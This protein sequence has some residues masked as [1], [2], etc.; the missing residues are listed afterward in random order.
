M[1]KDYLPV[2]KSF[3]AEQALSSEIEAA[4][5][6]P[7]VRCQ[8]ITATM[9]DVYLVTSHQEH[10][11]F[12]L[13][14][15]NQHT[16]AEI[17]A[18]WQFVNYLFAEGVSVAPAIAT[19]SSEYVLPISAPEGIRYGVLTTFVAGEHLRK[20]PGLDAVRAYGRLV[21]QIHALADVMPLEL[22]R[23][24]NDVAVI[25]NQ[26]IAAFEA[27]VS[28]H[29]EEIDYLHQCVPIL[30]A[31][32]ETLPQEKPF[33]GMIHGDVIRANSQVGDDGAVA[34]LDFDLCGLG[35]RV[36]D[37]AS[38]L[39]V[40]R[41]LPDELESER[42]FLEGYKEVRPLTEIEQEVIP[43]FEAI[44]AIFSIG[45]PAMNVYHWGSAY[46]HAYLDD[47]L[48]RLRYAMTKII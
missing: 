1:A 39:I 40:I 33:Y 43:V 36:Y 23:P 28:D 7:A 24:A 44:R 37:I 32:I 42:A 30:L 34:I 3:I 9:R 26:S 25:L 8:L 20:R 27:E 48:G 5:G 35:W 31:K 21:A 22:A 4:Y 12:Y 13:Y 14:R 47:S 19:K 41:G 38:Y 46:L 17:S 6:L 10:Y 29:Q 18:E 11:I 45:I 16:Q 15:H 2:V